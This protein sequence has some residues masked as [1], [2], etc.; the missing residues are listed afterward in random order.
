[1]SHNFID[2]QSYNMPIALVYAD[3][4]GHRTLAPGYWRIKNT[5][6]QF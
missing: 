6:G 4:R 2:T 3:G 5:N 1:M